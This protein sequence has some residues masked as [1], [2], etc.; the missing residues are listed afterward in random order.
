MKALGVLF[1]ATR[2]GPR[3][4]RLDVSLAKWHRALLGNVR[5]FL[6]CFVATLLAMTGKGS[7]S[8]RMR[9]GVGLWLPRKSVTDTGDGFNE[10]RVCGIRFNF[11]TQLPD[12]NTKVLQLILVDL[13]PDV[14]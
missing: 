6:D 7:G 10:F 14:F 11:L 1:V 5:R 13:P 2:R 9:C 12:V 8:L 3:P 4:A